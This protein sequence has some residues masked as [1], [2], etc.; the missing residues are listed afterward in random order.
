MIKKILLTLLFAVFSVIPGSQVFAAGL[1]DGYALAD[2]TVTNVRPFGMSSNPCYVSY[3]VILNDNTYSGENISHD[4]CHLEIG[5]TVKI[6]YLKSDPRK[7]EVASESQIKQMAPEDENVGVFGI[8]FGFLFI[9]PFLI[10]PIIPIIIIVM[11]VRRFRGSDRDGDGLGNDNKP[12]TAEQK[13]LIQEG[14]RKLGI[15]HEVKKKLTQAQ[16]RETLRE[17]DKQL[18]QK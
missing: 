2:G 16:A 15:H 7:H 18:K 9:V 11:V 5:D 12:A 3:E 13:K 17:I 8:I 6:K 1:Y 10:G 4:F 14:F